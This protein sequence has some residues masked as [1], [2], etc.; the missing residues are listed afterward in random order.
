MMRNACIIQ[1]CFRASIVS[2]PQLLRN[3]AGELDVNEEEFPDHD[4]ACHGP[5][6]TPENRRDHPQGFT[7]SCC[8]EN[9]RHPGCEVG[10]HVP[11]T[12]KR[13]M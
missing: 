12:K 10:Q 5:M 11:R 8:D 7:W 4:E 1:V 9:G 13:R 2:A 3:P 6:D